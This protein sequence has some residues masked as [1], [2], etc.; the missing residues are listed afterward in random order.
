[1]PHIRVGT[2][3]SIATIHSARRARNGMAGIMRMSVSRIVAG[4]L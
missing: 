4:T 3:A 1:M 2:A